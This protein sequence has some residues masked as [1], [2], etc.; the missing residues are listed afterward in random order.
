MVEVERQSA[1]RFLDT[2]LTLFLSAVQ[3]MVAQDCPFPVDLRAD[4]CAGA[5]ALLE[6]DGGD[7]YGSR[8][9]PGGVVMAPPVHPLLEHEGNP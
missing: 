9:L 1:Q 5:K 7:V 2:G 3:P 6:A 8:I 4:G